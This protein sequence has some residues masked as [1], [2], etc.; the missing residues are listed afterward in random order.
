MEAMAEIGEPAEN[1]EPLDKTAPSEVADLEL[2]ERDEQL[3]L[4]ARAICDHSGNVC[5][6]RWQDFLP[7][8]RAAIHAMS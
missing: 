8:A 2:I 4:V 3:Q 7:A 5:S 6:K 1:W